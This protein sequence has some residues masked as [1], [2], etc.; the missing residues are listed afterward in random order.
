MEEFNK[1]LGQGKRELELPLKF[2]R[3]DSKNIYQIKAVNI[4]EK[5]GLISLKKCIFRKENS[6]L[7][8]RDLSGGESSL[9]MMSIS[10]VSVLKNGSIILIDEPENSLHPSWQVEFI[11]LFE[12]LL[13]NFHGC[14]LLI[15]SHSPYLVSSLPSEKSCL[16]AASRDGRE[17]RYAMYDFG[18]YGWSIEKILLDIFGVATVRNS[19]FEEKVRKLITLMPDA[20]NKKSEIIFLLSYLKSF[21]MDSDDP[22]L[23]LI[24]RAEKAMT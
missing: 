4:A 19:Y 6:D 16:I 15:A 17:Y 24:S 8:I 3:F 13:A 2:S 9:I 20:R 18:T 22:L 10:I 23:N 1:V 11:G 12:K 21:R 7:E 14:H 5:F